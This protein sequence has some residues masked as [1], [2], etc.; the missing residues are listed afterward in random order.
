MPS[1]SSNDTGATAALKFGTSTVGNTAGGL[2]RLVG[3]V[4]GA[5]GRGVGDTIN[6]ATGSA[7]RPVGDGLNSLANGLEG[8]TGSIAKGIEDAGMGKAGGG[9]YF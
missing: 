8:G 7:G 4:V 6:G 1:S 2:T 9:K 3:G 5:A